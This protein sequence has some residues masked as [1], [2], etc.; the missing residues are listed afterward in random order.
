VFG[1][2]AALPVAGVIEPAVASIAPDV[3]MPEVGPAS[4]TLSF[5]AGLWSP[6]WA[7]AF[8]ILG[9]LMGLGWCAIAWGF[10]T[11]E[12]T[13]F[14]AG[15]KLKVEDIRLKGPAFY[16]TMKELPGLHALFRDGEAGDYDVYHI[17]GRYGSTVVK[18]LS[19][20]HTG[21]LPLYVAWCLVGLVIL[22]VYL[23]SA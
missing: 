5:P 19:S 3:A 7:T 1:V 11:R 2:W 9:V 15:E 13:V 18:I 16:E 21:R 20:A 6:G 22:V 14:A 10:K 17:G 12:T 4:A 8:I 23:V